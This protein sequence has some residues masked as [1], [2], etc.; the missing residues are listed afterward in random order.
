MSNSR[1]DPAFGA[2]RLPY[3]DGPSA[4]GFDVADVSASPLRQFRRWYDEARAAGVTEPN[5]MTLATVDDTGAPTAR[6]VLLKNADERGF[7]FFT[8][9]TSR[10]GTELAGRPVAALVF[11]WLPLH[12]QVGV[13][14]VV[15]RVEP[16]ETAEYFGSRPWGSRIGAW[17]SH[18]S[19][20][21]SSRSV[22]EERYEE[23][24]AR[25]PDRGGPE[26]VPVPP[27]WGG[28]L[29][30]PFE[31]EFWQGRAGRLHDRL[32][33]VGSRATPLLMDDETGWV[34]ERREP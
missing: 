3:T 19:A 13:R 30:R 12:R 34:L 10:K 32:V 27:F 7:T 17:A 22:F 26:D 11:P 6:T 25:W 16:A 4:T 2:Q 8:N 23:Y 5:A 24:A 14:G 9:Y 33:F 21:A 20:V 15:S 29:L 18:Q 31:I 28:F 1:I